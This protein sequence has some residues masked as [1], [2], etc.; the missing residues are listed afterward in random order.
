MS[1]TPKFHVPT[2]DISPYVSDGSA[3][4]RARVAQELDDACTTVG[5]IQILGHGIP[6]PVLDGLKWALDSFF[7]QELEAK[8][9]YVIEGANRGYTPPKSE[10]LSLSLGVESTSRMNDFFEAYNVGVEARSFTDLDLSESDYG[11][12]VWPQEIDGWQPAVEAYFAEARRVAHTMTTIFNDALVQEPGFFASITDHSIDVLRMNNYALP[13]G[14]VAPDGDLIGMSE[15][16][17]YGIVTVLWADQVAGLQVLGT[18]DVWHDVSPID[19]ALLIN[20]GDVTGR[21]TNDRW[22]STLHRV[23]PPVINGSVQRRRSVAFFHDGNADALIETLPRFLDADDGLAYEP[24]T[25]REHVLAK[26]AGS[27]QG[28]ANVA[29]A[30]EAARVVHS[31]LLGCCGSRAWAQ[32]VASSWPYASFAEL[33]GACERAFDGLAREDWL[34]AFAAHAP[35]GRPDAGDAR[36]TSEQA[37]IQTASEQARAEL[38]MLNA[39]YDQRFGHI[40]LICASGLSAEAMLAALRER[41]GNTADAEFEIATVEQRKITRLRLRGTFGT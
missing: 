5:F 25:V 10:S 16:T 4:E 15:H 21:L 19:N 33:L 35:I 26:L 17:D 7:G 20:L 29:A 11:I 30:R 41:L 8:K 34:E 1:R 23:K 18:D 32:T 2:V 37:G 38:S 31:Q 39:E 28:K 13:D 3:Q 27:R 24:I 6:E 14:T 40:F 9:R 22:M 12:N 36:G